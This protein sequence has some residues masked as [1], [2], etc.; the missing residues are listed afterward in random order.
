MVS[1]LARIARDRAGGDG[2][3]SQ[4]AQ[5]DGAWAW[6]CGD[7]VFSVLLG[8]AKMIRATAA[9]LLL[10][11][12]VAFASAQAGCIAHY[13]CRDVEGVKYFCDFTRNICAE[14][15]LCQDNCPG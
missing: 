11:S 3:C 7:H 13:E 6:L 14:C 10:G 1:V 9:V 15:V 2:V 4:H 8:H 12:L 5:K